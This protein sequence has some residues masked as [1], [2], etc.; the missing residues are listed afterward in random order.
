M[1]SGY[2]VISHP[3]ETWGPGA[4]G[5]FLLR[6][7]EW[8]SSVEVLVRV[9]EAQSGL[10]VCGAARFDCRTPHEAVYEMTVGRPLQTGGYTGRKRLWAAV[11]GA[12]LEE[13]HG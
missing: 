1:S 4:V 8:E 5:S 3:V 12:L 7:E 11:G 9:V 2:R 6:R 13:D 10:K